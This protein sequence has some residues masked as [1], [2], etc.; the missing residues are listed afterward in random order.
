MT[1]L[2]MGHPKQL[3]AK[4]AA[5]VVAAAGLVI[6]G[7]LMFC[8][9]EA[10]TAG[11]KRTKLDWLVSGKQKAHA[12]HEQDDKP[13]FRIHVEFMEKLASKQYLYFASNKNNDKNSNVTETTRPRPPGVP[14][15][16]RLLTID[17]PEVVQRGIAPEQSCEIVRQRIFAD[18]TAPP[19]KVQIQSVTSDNSKD[20]YGAMRNNYGAKRNNKHSK[21]FV[22][23]HTIEVEVVQKAWVQALHQCINRNT[24]KVGIQVME[25]STAN[26]N[27]YNIRRAHNFENLTYD[28]GRYEFDSATTNT[29]LTDTLPPQQQ[30]TL[31]LDAPW[32]Q[33]AWK[34]E[35]VLR[36]SGQVGFGDPMEQASPP[37]WLQQVWSGISKVQ[38]QAPDFSQ[39]Q[40]QTIQHG[41][42]YKST[43]PPSIQ[44]TNYFSFLWG[45]WN[46]SNPAG[47]DG[48]G[49]C[50]ASHKPHAVLCNGLLL[51]RER[52]ALRWLQ[53]TCRA[54]NVPLFVVGD[55]R[56]WSEYNNTHELDENDS[57]SNET[58]IGRNDYD[59]GFLLKQVRQTVKNRIV[60]ASLQHSAGTA[61]A[62]GRAFGAMEA[63]TAYQTKEWMRQAKLA[64]RE[65]RVNN[66]K[67]HAYGSDWSTL[68]ETALEHKLQQHSVLR[69]RLPAP[70]NNSISDNTTATPSTKVFWTT[71]AFLALARRLV[72]DQQ[73]HSQDHLESKSSSASLQLAV[74]STDSSSS[75]ENKQ[76]AIPV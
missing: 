26:L 12:K 39:Q 54:H 18:G 63:Q 30:E 40:L 35:L 38:T 76:D 9:P 34:E 71:D 1:V 69:R 20:N 8:G 56:K 52:Q 58:S 17:L 7:T 5:A 66:Q 59:L 32:H 37:S 70:P 15:H 19:A 53:T 33:Y 61:F 13:S 25:A 14:D 64:V 24:N 67:K 11:S 21:P 49:N 31:L 47:L 10:M 60:T 45:W 65:A 3:P 74:D 36:I 16:L 46:P 22:E 2:L 23:Q 28:P 68:D 43:V 51:Q 55:P 41:R 73:S 44:H 50:W 57:A 27:P 72:H 48:Q 42:V 4:S 29:T 75:D 62:R 6:G